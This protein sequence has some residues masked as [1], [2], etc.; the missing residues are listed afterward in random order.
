MADTLAWSFSAGGQSAGVSLSGT[1]E[2]D[3]LT[4]ATARAE[5][6]TPAVLALQIAD[7]AD[8]RL[9]AVTANRYDGSISVAG[10][11]AGDPTIALTG[12]IVAFGAAVARHAA[13]LGT[14]TVTVAGGADPADVEILIARDLTS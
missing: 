11:D 1:L 8:I 9:L 5:A 4:R 3:A 13:N 14:L 2:S 10:A 6:G 12:P 7:V